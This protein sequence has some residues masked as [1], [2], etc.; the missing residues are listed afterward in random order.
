MSFLDWLR[1]LGI[2]RFG[3]ESAVYHNAKERP[4]SLQ[5]DDVFNSEK[6][7]LFKHGSTKDEDSQNDSDAGKKGGK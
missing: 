5:Q 2:L 3:A 6:D 7:V 4:I 1:K